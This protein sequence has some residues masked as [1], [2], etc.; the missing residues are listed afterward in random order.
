MEMQVTISREALEQRVP[1]SNERP[2]WVDHF[3]KLV[4]VPGGEQMFLIVDA[5]ERGGEVTLHLM[6]VSS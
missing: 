1:R 2:P 4:A 6:P 5:E 3:I